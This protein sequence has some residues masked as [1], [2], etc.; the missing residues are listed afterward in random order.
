[1]LLVVLR[2]S[3]M[4]CVES[5]ARSV[6]AVAAADGFPAAVFTSLALLSAL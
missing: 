1:M 3:Y 6:A 5:T 4:Y 2:C